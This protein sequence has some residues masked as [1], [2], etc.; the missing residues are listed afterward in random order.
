[1]NVSMRTWQAT[2]LVVVIAMGVLAATTLGFAGGQAAPGAPNSKTFH[3]AV[4]EDP[5][6]PDITSVAVANNRTGEL[7]FRIGIP[8]R[9]V[10]T[11]DM[12]LTL[13]VDW[14]DSAATGLT[15]EGQQGVDM[16]IVVD[17]GLQG[18]GQAAIGGCSGNSC[19]T[20]VDP[21][22]LRFSYAAGVATFTLDTVR[23]EVPLKRLRFRVEVLG[24]VLFDPGPPPKWD[25][26]NVHLDRA[27]THSDIPSREEYW[28][29]D[30]RPLLV[31]SFSRAPLAPRAGKPFALR[32]T[33]TRTDTNTV[34]RRGRV[35]CS[36]KLRGKPL[37]ARS[38]GFVGQ[39]ATCAYAI[40][41][42]AKGLRYRGTISVRVD[43][44]TVS[45]SLA[46][47]VR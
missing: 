3:D 17:R 33:A 21:D 32:L 35:V 30:S 27:P 11:E 2:R 22:V 34:V 13:R 25:L 19:S 42:A 5:A 40:P 7:A 36:L 43:G 16:L 41:A 31:R 1:V 15:V 44:A 8:N 9:P 45:R 37:R 18:F 38:Q 46:G 26:A 20:G 4:G 6:A 23:F 47:R 10:L 29:Y 24:G 39:R 12:R 14:D 28:V